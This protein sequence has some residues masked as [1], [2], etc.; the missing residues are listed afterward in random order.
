MFALKY[1]MANV[2]LSDLPREYE[3]MDIPSRFRQAF[4][5]KKLTRLLTFVDHFEVNN[6]D[7]D[8]IIA[9]SHTRQPGE[10]DEDLKRRQT[11]RRDLEKYKSHFYDYSVYEKKKIA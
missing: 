4:G 9:T 3:N 10:S 6:T 5:A 1:F 2:P 11:L 8:E 7:Y